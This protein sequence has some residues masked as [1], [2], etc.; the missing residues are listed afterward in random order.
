MFAWYALTVAECVKFVECVK[1]VECVPALVCGVRYLRGMRY[2]FPNLG[3]QGLE[4]WFH[5]W[6][7]IW[8]PSWLEPQFPRATGAS[9]THKIRREH[10]ELHDQSC[11]V[12]VK[13][14]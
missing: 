3:D 8:H 12:Y 6:P 1:L 14:P 10:A 9:P 13:C 5:Q 4:Q 7:A 2:N 11:W